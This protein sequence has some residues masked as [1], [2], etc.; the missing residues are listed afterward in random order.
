MFLLDSNFLN[1]INLLK[2]KTK[3]FF[4]FYLSKIRSYYIAQAVPDPKDWPACA[5]LVLCSRHVPPYPAKR[6]ELLNYSFTQFSLVEVSDVEDCT[7]LKRV[8]T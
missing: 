8:H 6:S 2:L 4:W 7:C 5:S 1:H 3:Q